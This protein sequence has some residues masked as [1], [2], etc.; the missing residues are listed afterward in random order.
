MNTGEMRQKPLKEYLDT[1]NVLKSLEPAEVHLQVVNVFE[2]LP[3]WRTEAG[4]AS[5]LPLKRQVRTTQ[6][7]S[8]IAREIFDQIIPSKHEKENK[9]YKTDILDWKKCF[10][11]RLLFFGDSISCVTPR[12]AVDVIYPN[13]SVANVLQGKEDSAEIPI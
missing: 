12:A 1:S 7:C 3:L 8:S 13:S 11:T 5:P 6:A 9:D 10:Q 2:P 4:Q